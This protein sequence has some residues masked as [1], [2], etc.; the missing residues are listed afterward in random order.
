MINKA[1]ESGV[2]K[3]RVHGLLDG[4]DVGERS[5]MDYI[6]PLEE[7]L[8]SHNANGCDFKIAS[9]GGRMYMT[10]D[11][12]E[13]EPYMVERGWNTHVLGKGRQFASAEEAIKTYY[14]ELGCIDQDL[15]EFVIVE[16]G[17]PVGKMVDNDS[18]ILFNF[19]GDRG[20]EISLAFDQEEG[21]E[22]F[23]RTEKPKVLYAGMM[24]YDG[25]LHIP[26]RYLVD[27]PQIDRTIGEYVA[28]AEIKQL[29][30]SETQKYGHV[31][32]FFNGNR[33]AKFNDSLEDYIEIPSDPVPFWQ[34]PWMKA[35]QIT[36]HTVA[37]IQSGEYGFIRLNVPNGDMVGHTGNFQATAISCEA[38]DL[39]L[40]RIMDAIKKA[41]GILVVTADHGN[42]DEMYELD[43]QGNIK[44]DENGIKKNKTSHSL[45]PVPCFIYDPN[46]KGEYEITKTE[47]LGIS[48]VTATCIN[49]MGYQTPEGYDEPVIKFK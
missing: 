20:M 24:E 11:R 47:G 33:S 34:R 7:L 3:L 8:A 26:N 27:P 41:N 1:A 5:A 48:S 21:F 32:Y 43:K 44:C 30:I 14:E 37:G 19:R 17:E 29:A 38:A 16:N 49:L 35:A 23:E 15:Q 42:A 39:G 25:D 46:F 45:N 22:L 40:K 28:N 12:Y 6:G 10:M 13:A 36:D 31:T 9:G 2:K 18:V 4:R